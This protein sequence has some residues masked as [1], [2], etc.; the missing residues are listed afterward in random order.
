MN[1]PYQNPI[2]I[3]VKHDLVSITKAFSKLIMFAANFWQWLALPRNDHFN[4]FSCTEDNHHYVPLLCI[5]FIVIITLIT[6][7]YG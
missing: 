6:S 3:M 2:K 5:N 1:C 7:K 4:T